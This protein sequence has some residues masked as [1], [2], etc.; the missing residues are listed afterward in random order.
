MCVLYSAYIFSLLL[1]DQ[2]RVFFPISS[3][4]KNSPAA[5]RKENG[6]PFIASTS[7]PDT[8][9]F[10]FSFGLLSIYFDALSDINK[11]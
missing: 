11:S 7:K 9:G 10:P 6:K 2:L 3:M 8:F 4:T 1:G 5:N